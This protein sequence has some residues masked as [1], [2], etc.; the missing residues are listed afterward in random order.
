MVGF[1]RSLPTL[2]CLPSYLYITWVE[3]LILLVDLINGETV[4]RLKCGTKY[5]KLEKWT[6]V[7][8]CLRPFNKNDMKQKI[9]NSSFGFVSDTKACFAVTRTVANV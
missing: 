4:E 3:I 5:M 1:T 2:S 9:P 8:F 6:R 7:E